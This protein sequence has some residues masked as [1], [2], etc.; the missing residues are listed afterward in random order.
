MSSSS[1]KIVPIEFA[2]ACEFIRRFHRHHKPPQGHKFSI[3][4]ASSETIVGVAIVGRPLSRFF[5]N[6][7][8]LEVTRVCTDGTPNACSKLY[9]ACW[10]AAKG[11][12]Y[13]ELVTYILDNEKGTSLKAAGWTCLGK[14]GGKS[15]NVKSRPRIDK[16]P[17]QL[18]IK[19]GI[20]IASFF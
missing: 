10:R 5:D 2:E 14:A 13:L 8:I 3:A 12:G 9:A 1:L 6:G 19:Y 4:V 16:C 7:W 11:L 20:K 15:W 18:K 17:A